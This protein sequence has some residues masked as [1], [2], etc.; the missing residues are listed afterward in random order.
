[1]RINERLF[2]SSVLVNEDLQVAKWY[3]PDQVFIYI[4]VTNYHIHTLQYFPQKK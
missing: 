3:N 4:F 1:M 2:K